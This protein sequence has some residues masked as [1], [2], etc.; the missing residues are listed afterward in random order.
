[1]LKRAQVYCKKSDSVC[2]DTKAFLEE[3]GILVEERN[4]AKEPL[5]K[6]ELQTVLGFHNPKHYLDHT[7]PVYKKEG[8]DESMPKHGELMEL[9][10][11]N[12]DLLK[13]PIIVSGRLM[14]IGT[15]KKQL[16]DMFQISPSDNGSNGNRDSVD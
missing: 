4:I 7:S 3:H 14:T 16:M 8:L 5:T 13:Q 9:I 15:G 11:E 6:R 10:I 12:P 1:M 2:K